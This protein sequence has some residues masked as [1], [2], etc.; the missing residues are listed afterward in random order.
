MVL[1]AR[2]DESTLA[3]MN[4]YLTLYNFSRNVFFVGSILSAM[5]LFIGISTGNGTNV[6][7][8]AI[9]AVAAAGMFTRYLRFYRLY[10][11]EVILGYRSHL[12]DE[13]DT[14]G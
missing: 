5:Y 10:G 12:K 1:I 2:Q 9:F 13:A 11:L 4:R 7:I 6:L 3:R 14:S 8:G